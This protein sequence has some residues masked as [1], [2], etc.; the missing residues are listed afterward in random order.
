MTML[1]AR[2]VLTTL[3][4]TALSTCA[5]ADWTRVST[6]EDGKITTYADPATT[7]T[8]GVKVQLL[9]LTDYQEAQLVSGEQKF[10]SVKMQDEFNCEDKTGRHLN[11]SAMSENMGKGQTVAVEMKPAPWRQIKANTADADMMKFVCEKK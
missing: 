8:L 3:A 7:Q 11:L 5:L 9:T 6:S 10:R 1:T 2:T 4:L